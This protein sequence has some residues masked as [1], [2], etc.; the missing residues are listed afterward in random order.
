MTKKERLTISI[1]AMIGGFLLCGFAM[2][3]SMEP[4]FSTL[5]TVGG[6]L[7]GV[8]GFISLILAMKLPS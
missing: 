5:C 6:L 4:R 8:G 3:S 2:A 1:G 7:I